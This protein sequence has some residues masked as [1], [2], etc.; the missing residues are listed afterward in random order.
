MSTTII[1]ENEHENLDNLEF[2]EENT[3]SSEQTQ[4]QVSSVPDKYKG[5]TVE[6]VIKMHQE[7]EKLYGRQAEE[8]GFARKMAE[9]ASQRIQQTQTTQQ[10]T[11]NENSEVDFFVD[12]EKAVNSA[13][14]RA[15]KPLKEEIQK[16]RTERQREV[17]VAKHPDHETIIADPEFAT[18]ITSS[19][20]RKRLFVEAAQNADI[21]AADELLTNYKL[22]K[23]IQA[24]KEEQQVENVQQQQSKALKAAKTV[25]GANS[26]DTAGKKIYSRKALEHLALTNPRKYESM[27]T[28]IYAAY[29]E[30][31]VR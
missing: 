4:E 30:G 9:N 16:S 18:W 3:D 14:E 31:R 19:N 15:T 1:D 22:F 7:L 13:V 6:D 25:T 10:K 5:K 20:V 26:G 17:L 27:E 28:E 12:P 2:V 29:A 23:G 21:E 24:K 8:I 11:E